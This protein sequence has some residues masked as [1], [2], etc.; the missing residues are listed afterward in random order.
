MFSGSIIPTQAILPRGR[1]RLPADYRPD[2]LERALRDGTFDAVTVV[3]SETSTG[4]L[5]PLAEIAAAV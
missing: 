3:H 2:S 4:V 5:N 1:C